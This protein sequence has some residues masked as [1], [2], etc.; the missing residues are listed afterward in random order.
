MDRQLYTSLAQRASDLVTAGEYAQALALLEEIIAGDLPDYDKAMMC[1]NTAVVYD[2]WGKPDDALTSYA[3]AMDYERSTGSCFV[4]QHRAA[5]FSQLG[6]YDES[7]RCYEELL[8]RADLSPE[9][10]DMF[11]KNVATL[12]RLRDG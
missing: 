4:A 9:D 5:Y 7:L 12:A 2:K 6:R 3:R 1:L 10:R 11:A 8:R